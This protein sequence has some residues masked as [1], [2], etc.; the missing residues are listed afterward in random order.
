MLLHSC[1]QGQP[2][3]LSSCRSGHIPLIRSLIQLRESRTGNVFG[4]DQELSER[5]VLMSTLSCLMLRVTVIDVLVALG[6]ED[7]ARRD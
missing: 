5:T 2:L 3:D 7:E 4:L 6:A 1:L